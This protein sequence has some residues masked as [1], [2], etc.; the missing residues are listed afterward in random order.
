V[1]HDI[2]I[3]RSVLGSLLVNSASYDQA[4]DAGVAPEDFYLSSHRII[5]RAIYGLMRS[6]GQADVV[7]L[8]NQLDAEGKLKEV[9]GAAYIA[10]LDRGVPDRGSISFHIG[11][12]LELS[13]RRRLVD[14]CNL[15]VKQAETEESAEITNQL[16][17]TVNAISAGMDDPD[18][19]SCMRASDAA[20]IEWEKMN[21]RTSNLIGVPTG[22]PMLDLLNAG[23]RAGEYWIFGA[24]PGSGKSAL[25]CQIARANCLA[26]SVVHFFSLEMSKHEILERMWAA[27][28]DVPFS[29]IHKARCNSDD[30]A[31]VKTAADCV[32]RW[33]LRLCDELLT[34]ERIVA[35]AKATIRRFNTKLVIVDFLQNIP[36][37]ERDPRLGIN[38]VSQALRGLAHMTGVPVV[39]FSQLRRGKDPSSRPTMFDL[40]E[41]GQL[42]QDAHL[43]G[44]LYR[45]QGEA[46]Q[47][48][49]ED[50]LFIDKNR[51]GS[52]G[53]I[54][55][56]FN[57]DTMSFDTRE[58][59]KT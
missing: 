37:H 12:L 51:H 36:H 13:R 45:P 11:K 23:V 7:A 32:S 19:D 46:N 58:N 38:H 52:T 29:R 24:W 16:L 31:K 54:A 34:A 10:D 3:E 48:T 22:V 1:T 35:R 17:G 59:Y 6:V 2:A 40:R 42:E 41:S 9:G 56:R 30:E 47:P 26:G 21:R 8:C 57:P 5:C 49:G 50:V 27:Q 39:A 53:A 44:L 33:P 55:L 15:A 4:S 20:L 18:A 14:A 43:V 28:S 25:A